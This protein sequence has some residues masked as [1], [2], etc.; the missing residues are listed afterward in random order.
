[1]REN[2]IESTQIFLIFLNLIDFNLNI[3]S[4]LW[5]MII[6]K[7]VTPLYFPKITVL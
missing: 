1:M 7:G 2:F 3:Y 4:I 5:H 6:S